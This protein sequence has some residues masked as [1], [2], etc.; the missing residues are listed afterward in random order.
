VETLYG[1]RYARTETGLVVDLPD[2]NRDAT[3]VVLLALRT[4][5]RV[6]WEERERLAVRARL[7]YREAGTDRLRTAHAEASVGLEPGSSRDPLADPE[8]RKNFTIAELAQ[9]MHDMAQAASCQRWAAADSVLRSAVAVARQ[10]FPSGE[11]QDLVRV[12]T[13]AEDCQRTLRQHVDRFRDE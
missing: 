9:A 10:R 5:R 6:R 4:S 8:L 12:L 13:M 7:D 1:H 3:G 2:L 11:D